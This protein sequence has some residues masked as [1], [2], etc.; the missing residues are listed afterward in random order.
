M[1]LTDDE[2]HFD[3]SQVTVGDIERVDN[4]LLKAVL[5]KVKEHQEREPRPGDPLRHTEHS[6]HYSTYSSY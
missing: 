2:V 6:V 3:L 1:E 5:R 4:S